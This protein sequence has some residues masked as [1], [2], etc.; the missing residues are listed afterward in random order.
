MK[1]YKEMVRTVLEKGIVSKDRTGVGTIRI[2]S[3]NV[4]FDL[5]DGTVPVVTGKR[6]ATKTL[7]KELLWFIDG[8]QSLKTLLA[9]FIYL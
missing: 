4:K 8:E 6:T 7:A 5:S 3:Y 9:R 1:Q 2:P